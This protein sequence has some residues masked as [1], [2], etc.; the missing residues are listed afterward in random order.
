VFYAAGGGSSALPQILLIV[1][2]FALFYFLLMRPMRRR[3]QAAAAAQDKM[4]TELTPGDEI[5]T[6]GGLMATVV[7]A[8]EDSVTLELS[9]GVTAR[10][11]VKA[12]ARIVTP[13]ES[14]DTPAGDSEPETANN[15][16]IEERD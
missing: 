10:Y 2:F 14:E 5:V 11:D 9:P 4:R 13:T 15:S 3:Q 7:S 1:L 16:V 6:I 8:N 12:I